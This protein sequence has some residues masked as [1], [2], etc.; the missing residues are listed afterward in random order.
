MGNHLEALDPM[1]FLSLS[2]KRKKAV[3]SADGNVKEHSANKL[4]SA[5][6]PA[7]QYMTVSRVIERGES[8]ASYVLVPN[9]SKGTSSCAYFS[10]GQYLSVNV[11]IDGVKYN[12]PYTITSSPREALKGFYM[13][14]VKACEGG[15]VSNHILK[16]W[17]EGTEVEVSEPMGNFTY[18]PLRDERQILGIAGGSGI[19]PFISLAKAISDGDEDCFLTLLYGCRTEKEILFK[20]ELGNL[21]SK[22]DKIKVIYV[23]SDERKAHY[24]HGLI[25]AQMIKKYAPKTPYSVFVCGPDA[26]HHAIDEEL[27]AFDLDKKYVRHELHGTKYP[28]PEKPISICMDVLYQGERYSI[29]GSSDRTILENLE[30]GG[31]VSKSRCRSGECGF[32]RSRLLS[33]MVYIPEDQDKRRRADD[34]Y[35]YIHPCCT[36]PLEDIE[37]EIDSDQS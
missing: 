24:E 6:H 19:T 35:G 4:A 13:I 28:L 9:K 20:R 18:E 32:C 7:R 27:R 30:R 17:Q 11:E 33:G 22:C 31:I 15:R 1:R 34:P 8:C 5:L 36:Y 29:S 37:I 3:L 2:E 21:A 23:L 25:S 16:A 10:A 12:R 26:Q 14:T